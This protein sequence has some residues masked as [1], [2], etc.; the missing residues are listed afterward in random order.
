MDFSSPVCSPI[1]AQT[2]NQK[3]EEKVIPRK[4]IPFT[5]Y[6]DKKLL[7]LVKY[8]GVD[9][10]YVWD[11]VSLSMNGRNSRQCRER[12][13]LFLEDGIK[14]KVQWTK[15]EDEILLSKYELH[16]PHWKLMEKYFTGRTSYSIKNRF[17]SLKRKEKN[18]KKSSSNN[19]NDDKIT[20]I[21]TN[22]DDLK[23]DCSFT[24][25]SDNYDNYFY[26]FQ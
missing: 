11:L 24:F 19:E 16:G 26:I 2:S 15:E 13:K 8:Y 20:L 3:D 9:K 17:I 6:E 21:S 10:K 18:K 25:G 12:Y 7:E 14:R 4:R 23:F 1:Q 5:P 22:N